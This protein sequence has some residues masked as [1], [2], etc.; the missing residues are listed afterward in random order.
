MGAALGVDPEQ[1]RVAFA[2]TWRE[3]MIGAFGDLGAQCRRVARGLGADPTDDQVAR[4]VELRFAF[5]RRAIVVSD[6]TLAVLSTLR[7]DGLKLAIVSNCT[8]DSGAV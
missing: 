1:F 4:A 2:Q 3:R 5:N 6:D 8:V 7:A